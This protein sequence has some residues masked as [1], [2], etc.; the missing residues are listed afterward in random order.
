MSIKS[1]LWKFIPS[2][3]DF[4]HFACKQYINRYS[5]ENNGNIATN[6]ELRVMRTILPYC[7]TIFD[8]GA[9]NGE[10]TGLALKIKKDLIV[11]C[12]E[13]SAI[14]FEKLND[15]NFGDKILCNNF[16]LSSVSGDLQLHVFAD[17]SG[18]NS[19]YK[20]R[21]LE[22][23]WGLLPQSRV[24]NV[25]VETIDSYCEKLNISFIDFLKIDVEGHELEVIKGSTRM[26]KHGAIKHI[27][28][29]YGGCYIDSRV[30]L[31]D[32]FDFLEPYK[33]NF[34]KIYPN[35]LRNAPRYDQR[36]ENFQYQN[37]IAIRR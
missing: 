29:E 5:G 3:N 23:G 11:H 35:S 7:K 8:V 27:Q 25:R 36:Y 6:G 21:G 13:P 16:G 14:T 32:L 37:W 24:E 2:R 17:G 15:R 12:F 10:W 33:Y 20:R 31:K 1:I 19:L 9:N 26:L 18:E 30:L 4:L 28:F 34:Y 22:D